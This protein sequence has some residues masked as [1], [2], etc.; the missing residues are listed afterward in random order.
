VRRKLFGYLWQTAKVERVAVDEAISSW[1][2]CPRVPR[3]R[4]APAIEFGEPLA[5]GCKFL[6]VVARVSDMLVN[7]A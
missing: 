4:R 3:A 5:G 2:E 7:N 1:R 6:L